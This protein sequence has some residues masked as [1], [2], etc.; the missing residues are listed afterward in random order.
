VES[1][2]RIEPGRGQDVR[3]KAYIY[4]RTCGRR[5]EWWKESAALATGVRVTMCPSLSRSPRRHQPGSGAA[6][7]YL[8][9]HHV[10]DDAVVAGRSFVRESVCRAPA[11]RARADD[12]RTDEMAW[13]RQR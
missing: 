6:D 13:A 9:G 7:P 12:G 4:V 3:G 5:G 1:M 8:P 10:R 2:M 11:H